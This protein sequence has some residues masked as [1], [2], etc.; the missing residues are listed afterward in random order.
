MSKNS[1]QP[2]TGNRQA[3]GALQFPP[4]SFNLDIATTEWSQ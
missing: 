3:A 1:Q 2:A 4:A